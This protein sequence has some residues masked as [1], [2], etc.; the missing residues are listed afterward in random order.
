M[1]G[2]EKATPGATRRSRVS[3]LPHGLRVLLANLQHLPAQQR[4]KD[5]GVAAHGEDVHRHGHVVLGEEGRKE[6]NRG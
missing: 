3:R 4:V 1:A 2:Q 5:G 6:K